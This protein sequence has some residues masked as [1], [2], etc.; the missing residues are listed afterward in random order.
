MV[1]FCYLRSYLGIWT[2][3]CR[4]LLRV[5]RVEM[6]AGFRTLEKVGPSFSSFNFMLVKD[7]EQIL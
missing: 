4:L 3:F 1:R 6:D 5:A 2:I 7:T